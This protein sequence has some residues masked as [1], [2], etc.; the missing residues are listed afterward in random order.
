MS[1]REQPEPP[2]QHRLTGE[3]AP[4][5]LVIGFTLIGMLLAVAAA[6]WLWMTGQPRLQ[7]QPSQGDM[8]HEH[9]M[10]TTQP[11]VTSSIGPILTPAETPKVAVVR[12]EQSAVLSEAPPPS[13]PATTL[14]SSNETRESTAVEA[15]T[16]AFTQ[17][18]PKLVD[19]PPAITIPFERGGVNP[20]ITDDIQA[21]LARLREWLN[22]HP[23][24]KLS[25][26]GHADSAGSERRNLLLS[27][28]RA[29][30]VAVF[31]NKA[32]VPE[33][34]MTLLAAG[35]YDPLEG[36]PTDSA[37]NRRVFLQIKGENCQEVPTDSE[38]S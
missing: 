28:L 29:K 26:E 32:G 33:Q 16:P 38:R 3:D 12:K 23:K 35:E 24:A 13:V 34:Q 6:A 2:E 18:P 14:A 1:R 8:P 25:V 17:L 19:C 36:I 11:A 37:E 22:D 27:H 20:V 31:L 30:S 4:M 15:T 7:E 10:A 5:W 9:A 21:R